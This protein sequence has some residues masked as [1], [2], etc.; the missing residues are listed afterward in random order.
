MPKLHI[1][2]RIDVEKLKVLESIAKQKRKTISSL[3]REIVDKYV[4]KSPPP[5][6]ETVPVVL[7]IYDRM[8]EILLSIGKLPL[9]EAATIIY[10]YFVWKYGNNLNELDLNVFLEEIRRIFAYFCKIEKFTF[11]ETEQ[12]TIIHIRTAS[13]SQAAWISQL[14]KTTISR[15]ISH[16]VEVHSSGRNVVLLIAL[17]QP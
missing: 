16:E 3:L 2:F 14:I 4:E 6:F 17:T 7:E 12:N 11:R 1:S 8:L 15:L 5:F 13:N 10:N 9:E